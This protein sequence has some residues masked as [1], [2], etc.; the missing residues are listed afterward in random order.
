[1]VL[2]QAVTKANSRNTSTDR[3]REPAPELGVVAA[4]VVGK[5]GNP[6]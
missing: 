3:N 4:V 6:H 5:I 1:M 2:V